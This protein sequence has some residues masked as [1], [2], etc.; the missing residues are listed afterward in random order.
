MRMFFQPAGQ[1]FLAAGWKIQSAG[2]FFP[3]LLLSHLVLTR[4]DKHQTHELPAPKLT[5]KT[6]RRG[7][8]T[9]KL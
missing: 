7:N 4:T 2:S 1:L 3:S 8:D 9:L 6:A 5:T